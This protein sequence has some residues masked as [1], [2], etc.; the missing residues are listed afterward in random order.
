MS[1][2]RRKFLLFL[3]AA[4]GTAAL[5]PLGCQRTTPEV[6]GSATSGGAVPGNAA[7]GGSAA[8]E[9]AGE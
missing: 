9:V 8:G 7:S 2:K 4:A 5:G 3:G 1:F 6:S